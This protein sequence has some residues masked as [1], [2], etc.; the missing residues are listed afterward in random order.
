[1]VDQRRQPIAAPRP[2]SSRDMTQW[3]PASIEAVDTER[4]QPA[5]AGMEGLVR[6]RETMDHAHRSC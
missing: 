2:K 4:G 6:T 5:R 3:R 1:M